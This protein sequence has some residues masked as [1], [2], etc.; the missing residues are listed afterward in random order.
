MKAALYYHSLLSWLCCFGG[1]GDMHD[2]PLRDD[3]AVKRQD[4]RE[5]SLYVFHNV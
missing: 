2:L 1:T 5:I 4:I 3:R